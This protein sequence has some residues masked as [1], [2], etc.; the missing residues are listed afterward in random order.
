[1]RNLYSVL[2]LS[3]RANS[4]DI[5][6][7]YWRL[8]KRFHPD[9]NA[10]DKE[11]ERWTKEINRAYEVLGDPDA[12]AAYDLESSRR[13][14][15]AR[16]SFWSAAAAGAVT[17]M[18]TAASISTMMVWKPQIRIPK[19][20]TLVANAPAQERAPSSSA[21][22]ENPA[23]SAEPS[24]PA[25][26]SLP[27]ASTELPASRS[28]ASTSSQATSTPL[29]DREVRTSSAP[30]PSSVLMEQAPEKGEPGAA[31]SEST[32]AD[33]PGPPTPREPDRQPPSRAELASVGSPEAI[34]PA[35]K[36]TVDQK[37]SGE[38]TRR[39]DDRKEVVAAQTINKKPKKHVNAG[40]VAAATP[41][42]LQASERVP[43]LVSR[44]AT[45]LRF[46]SADEPFVNLGVR[47]K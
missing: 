7:A 8:A 39:N 21:R 16:R 42:K 17:F 15:K 24:E 27:G 35:L 30:L 23:R 37:S 11:A 6:T 33:L 9:V 36:V 18:L 44:G 3:R 28:S 47:N 12:R 45:A 4:E 34:Q 2:K 22:S 26:A 31:P 41:S 46:P 19:S 29:T 25:S 13:R 43:H 14:A 1:M 5:K 32:R 20:V 38:P 10:G 40:A